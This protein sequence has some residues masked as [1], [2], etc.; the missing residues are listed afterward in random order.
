MLLKYRADLLYYQK[1]Y[2][3]ALTFYEA[4]LEAVPPT[5][6]VVVREMNQSLVKCR[7]HLKQPQ[8]ALETAWLLVSAYILL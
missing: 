7:L 5:N 6:N 3:S 2:E 1:Q 8:L 4:T